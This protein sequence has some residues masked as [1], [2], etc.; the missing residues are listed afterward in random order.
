MFVN[1]RTSFY[2]NNEKRVS[3]ELVSQCCKKN[4]KNVF[5]YFINRHQ[6]IRIL[7]EIRTLIIT[8]FVAK[9]RCF[10]R[11]AAS[12]HKR[13]DDNSYNSLSPDSVGLVDLLGLR[14]RKLLLRHQPRL[15]NSAN[16]PANRHRVRVHQ[17]EIPALER[18]QQVPER[19][20]RQ[21]SAPIGLMNQKLLSRN[22]NNKRFVPLVAL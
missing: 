16:I 13:C 6:N 7:H 11:Y 20:A 18:Q 21:A 14:E 15:H 17:A 19:Q 3:E 22:S 4:S 8:V 10:C 5:F 12:V 2:G 9:N 1:K